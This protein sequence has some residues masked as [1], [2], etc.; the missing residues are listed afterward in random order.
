MTEG[1]AGAMATIAIEMKK[2]AMR[3]KWNGGGVIKKRG[4]LT[5]IAFCRGVT[6]EDGGSRP[7]F[8]I[9]SEEG[10]RCSRLKSNSIGKRCREEKLQWWIKNKKDLKLT[11]AALCR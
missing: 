8:P 10:S 4:R 5:V 6:D 7:L 1:G 3:K 2:D 11:A 9:L